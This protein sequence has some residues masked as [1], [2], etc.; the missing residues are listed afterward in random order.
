MATQRPHLMSSTIFFGT[1]STLQIMAYSTI[2][3]PCPLYEDS[4]APLVLGTYMGSLM[5]I[6]ERVERPEAQWDQKN[7]CL[8]KLISWSS[9]CQPIVSLSS[10]ELKYNLS[11]YGQEL[12]HLPRLIKKL[13]LSN[14]HKISLHCSFVDILDNLSNA[15]TPTKQVIHLYCDN[16]PR[17]NQ[18]S[19]KPNISC[20]V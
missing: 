14:S 6:G 10:I 16:V 5:Q 3:T 4:L 2:M 12:V 8:S 13:E 9:K 19:K 7:S 1:L 11:N 18:A 15:H 17:S 20:Q